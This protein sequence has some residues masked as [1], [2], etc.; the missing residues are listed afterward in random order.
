[1]RALGQVESKLGGE[2]RFH[3]SPLHERFKAMFEAH[4][5]GRPN[6]EGGISRKPEGRIHDEMAK[7]LKNWK[8]VFNY[9]AE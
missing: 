2:G 6:P 8:I 4:W 7:L 1:M 3:K 9:S 5:Y